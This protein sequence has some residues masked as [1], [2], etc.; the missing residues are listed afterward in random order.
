MSR[1][2]VITGASSGIGAAAATRLADKGER[3]VVVGRTPE[4]VAA[5]AD[6]LNVESYVADFSSL[7]S[8]RQLA[9]DLNKLDR[10]D[11]LVNNAGIIS[12]E[13]VT[14]TD[15][16]ELTF[17]VNHLA[18]FLLTRLLMPKLIESHASVIMTSSMAHYRGRLTLG[19]LQMT[20]D[21][22]PFKAY[23]NTK[24]ANVL[25]AKGLHMHHALDGIS[26]T[27]FHPGV[28]S[29]QFG[30]DDPGVI[31]KF[32]RS[33]VGKRFMLSPH[34]G[35]DTLVWLARRRPPRDWVPG[36]YYTNRHQVKPNA[37]ALNSRLVEAFYQRS[38]RLSVS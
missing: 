14:T 27:A 11:V 36:A 1:T 19:D 15:G 32:Y 4:R 3:V 35:A 28:V 33:R 24:L 16:F 37:Q 34:A 17:Q 18:G 29:T 38:M 31:G 12:P 9:D 22:A 23:A 2:I 26:A 7:S 20:R 25:F 10:I 5:I 6:D 30:G 21:W 8:V 13:R